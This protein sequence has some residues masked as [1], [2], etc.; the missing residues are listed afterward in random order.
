MQHSD[1]TILYE[2]GRRRGRGYNIG[3]RVD[4]SL[5][6]VK[7]FAVVLFFQSDD[8]TRVPVVR[9]DDS[10]HGDGVEKDAHVD[11][12]DRSASSAVKEYDASIESWEDG[13]DYI[14]DNWKL[15]SD[16]YHDYHGETLRADGANL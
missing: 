1:F 9:V 6:N 3:V 16:R 4:P 5:N 7:S 11:R 8:G 13:I 12:Y 14:E 15:F 10:S 2:V